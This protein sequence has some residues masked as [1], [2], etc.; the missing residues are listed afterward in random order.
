MAIIRQVSPEEASGKVK[1]VYEDIM[2]SLGRLYLF[3]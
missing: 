2:E 3:F 1:E